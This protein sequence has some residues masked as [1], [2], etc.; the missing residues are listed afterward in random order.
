MRR[1]GSSPPP[2]TL[3]INPTVGPFFDGRRAGI[4]PE[5][6]KS[7]ILRFSPPAPTNTHQSHRIPTNL[8]T[9]KFVYNKFTWTPLTNFR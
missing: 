5:N 8:T 4:Q 9:C 3:D 2:R 7:E 1:G 6:T